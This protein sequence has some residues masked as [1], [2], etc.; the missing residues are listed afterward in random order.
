MSLGF[1]RSLSVAVLGVLAFTPIWIAQALAGSGSRL[2]VE[3]G[4]PGLRIAGTRLSIPLDRLAI[5]DTRTGSI[6]ITND[7]TRE[8]SYTLAA[9]IAG[10][11]KLLGELHL[12]LV[13]LGPH[14][15]ATLY[16]GSLAALR[17]LELGRLG[18]GEAGRFSFRLTFPSTGSG[19]GDNALEGREAAASFNWSVVQ[20]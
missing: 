2:R 6:T 10:D 3:R 7:G 19:A 11:E 8:G 5:G 15:S 18:P 16:T 17:S 9:S 4:T 1:R 20:A 14:G 13:S 12:T